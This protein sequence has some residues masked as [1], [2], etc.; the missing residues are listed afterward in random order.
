M[1]PTGHFVVHSLRGKTLVVRVALLATCP[2]ME[3]QSQPLPS[4]SFDAERQSCIRKHPSWIHEMMHSSQYTRTMSTSLPL[5]SMIPDK[6][7]PTGIVSSLWWRNDLH[8]CLLPVAFQRRGLFTR[9][10][11]GRRLRLV[12]LLFLDNVNHLT[13]GS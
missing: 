1:S 3:A 9:R 5:S 10:W 4:S 7:S 13:G 11:C 6:S 8:Q 2:V 12:N